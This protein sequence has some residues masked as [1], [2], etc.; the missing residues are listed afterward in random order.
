VRLFRQ[1]AAREYHSVIDRM[2]EELVALTAKFD[3]DYRCAAI[4]G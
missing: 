1:N 4:N 3:V 2:R